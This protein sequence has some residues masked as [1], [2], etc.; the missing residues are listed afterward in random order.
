MGGVWLRTVSHSLVR[1]DQIT[2]IA[3]SR[4]SVHEEKGYSLKVVIDGRPHVLIDNSDLPGTMAQRLDQAQQMQDALVSA[5]DAA[6]SMGASMVISHA[7]ES[8]RWILTAAAD[9]AGEPAPP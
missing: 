4:G 2:E 8:E 5:I 6:G 1:A 9:L 3:C 7:P